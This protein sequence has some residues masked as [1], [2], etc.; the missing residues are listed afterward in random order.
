MDEEIFEEPAM[1]DIEPPKRRGKKTDEHHSLLQSFYGQYLEGM[2]EQQ[3]KEAM[4]RT[5]MTKPQINKYLWD[6]QE[7]IYKEDAELKRQQGLIFEV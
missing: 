4:S 3:W 6:Q 1:P 7:R 2:N 5:G